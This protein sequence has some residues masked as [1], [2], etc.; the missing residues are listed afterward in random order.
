MRQQWTL[1]E[2]DSDVSKKKKRVITVK[3]AHVPKPHD[4]KGKVRQFR[5]GVGLPTV[6]EIREELRGYRQVLLGHDDPPIALRGKGVATLMEYAEGV[7]SRACDI[8]QLILEAVDQ[9]WISKSSS[10][11]TL[12]TQELR[13]FKEMSR[14]A[15]ELGSRR[16]TYE[17]LRVQQEMRGL[18]S[19]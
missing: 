6:E 13:S 10:Y 16:I 19:L 18:E 2:E 12:R 15:A 4:Y 11:H 14:S 1:A 5:L 9:G 7:F 3:G 17:N 8:E